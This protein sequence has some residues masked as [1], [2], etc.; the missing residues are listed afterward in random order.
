MEQGIDGFLHHLSA[1]KS[2]SA[3]VDR[4]SGRLESDTAKLEARVRRPETNRG[5]ASEEGA[6]PPKRQSRRKEERE[7]ARSGR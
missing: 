1:I 7:A 4:R 6:A 2:S 5:P 3:E